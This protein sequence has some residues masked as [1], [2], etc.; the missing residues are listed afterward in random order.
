MFCRISTHETSIF[1][2]M[3]DGKE[4]H[5]SR[6]ENCIIRQLNSLKALTKEELK[7]I[8]DSKVTKNVKKG[9]VL[10]EE[11]ER[12]N[13]VF[14][15]R[16]GVSKLSKMS[17]NGKDQIIKIAT[18]GE[19][20]GQRS[21]I[22]EEKTNLS[23][24]A[25]NDMEVCYIPKNHLADSIN[26]NVAFT[27]AVL[28]QMANELKFADN[29]I[30]NMAQ[31]TVKQRIAE[32]LLYLQKNFGE[33]PEG[34]ISMTLTREDIANVVGTAKEACIRMLTSFKKESWITTDG[35]RIK[36]EDEKALQRLVDGY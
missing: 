4:I 2:V 35:K 10:F 21:V 12:L 6:C 30:V 1:A 31:K 3:E 22:A 34:Y 7:K 11:G 27:K 24:V 19:L 36:I 8:S 29:V 13:G 18:K 26:D 14:C 5:H 15:V 20:L 33:D 28:V 17:D 23:A 25:L 32:S 9:E 16:S